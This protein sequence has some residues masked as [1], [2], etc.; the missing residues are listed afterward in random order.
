VR[1][2]VAAAIAGAA[3]VILV[4]PVPPAASA[5]PAAPV[6]VIVEATAP[7]LAR[8]AVAP[9]AVAPVAAS[10]SHAPA[11]P[12][13]ARF[14]GHLPAYVRQVIVVSARRWRTTYGVVTLWLRVGA[15][16]RRAVSW[17]ARLGYGGL[18]LGSRRVQSTGT[19][20]VGGY[21]ITQAFGRMPNPGTALPFT[22]VTDDDWW[23]EDRR[24]AY[25]NQMRRASLGGFAVTTRGYNGS[26]HLA[27]MGS[28]YDYVAVIDFNRPNPVIGRG[29]GIFL[30]AYGTGATAGCVAIRHDRM[31]A[32]LR[33]LRA[34]RHPWIL[35][36][37]SS[38]LNA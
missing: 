7:G 37:P 21:P 8:S 26:E 6:G 17:P 33:W 28:Q 10:A 9:V 16:W 3:A 34:D 14:T 2:I 18:V 13:A 35:I 27:R 24:S 11:V 4:A 22:R 5:P 25:Y 30:H 23:V 38:W 32:A 1:R 36:G 29:A 31:R 20:P 12:G 15:G 19:T